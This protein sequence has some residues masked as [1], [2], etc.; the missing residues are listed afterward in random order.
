MVISTTCI[1]KNEK[2]SRKKQLSVDAT[3]HGKRRQRIIII[4]L[5]KEKVRRCREVKGRH[6]NGCGRVLFFVHED[7]G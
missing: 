6:D 4:I 5:I 7:N 3:S 2:L 1:K